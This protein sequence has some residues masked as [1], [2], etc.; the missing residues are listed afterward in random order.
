MPILKWAR[1]GE[2]RRDADM[3]TFQTRHYSNERA[4]KYVNMEERVFLPNAGVLPRRPVFSEDG[5]LDFKLPPRNE[6]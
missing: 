3:L 6:Y 2:A 1:P 4:P 5:S